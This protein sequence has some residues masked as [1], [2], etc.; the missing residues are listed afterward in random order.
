MADQLLSVN[1]ALHAEQHG[2]AGALIA[3]FAGAAA[4]LDRLNDCRLFVNVVSCVDD[5]VAYGDAEFD[6][7]R[8][9][10]RTREFIRPLG[11]HLGS[12]DQRA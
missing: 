3:H 6:K 12:A 11:G 5:P 2:W 1:L 8:R 7:A 10:D 9:C 4:T